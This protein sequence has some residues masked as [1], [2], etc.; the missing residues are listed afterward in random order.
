VRSEGSEKAAIELA[1][2][3]NVEA[4]MNG[5]FTSLFVASQFGN[6]AVVR[7]L[8]ACGANVEAAT[9]DDSFTP[10]IMASFRGHVDVVRALLAAGAD[11]HHVANIGATATS[12][13]GTAGGVKLSAK[14][15]VLALLATAP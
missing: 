12:V 3:A 2:G 4:A 1:C 5:G 8:L 6:L 14:A 13:A 11:K 9:A 10:L 7:E 15:A